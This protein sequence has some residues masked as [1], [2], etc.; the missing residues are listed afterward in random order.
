MIIPISIIQ[1]KSSLT[2]YIGAYHK[3]TFTLHSR[4]CSESHR[5][6]SLVSFEK[7]KKCSILY[8]SVHC[9][10]DSTNHNSWCIIAMCS[11]YFCEGW[12]EI[13]EET[14]SGRPMPAT[15]FKNIEGVKS[16]IKDN[17]YMTRE[18]LQEQTD[19]SHKS[20]QQSPFFILWHR[21]L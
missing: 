10:S 1:A 15:T 14:R 13:E 8:Q 7:D 11:K 6:T 17:P 3:K 4:G 2:V 18:E 21:F 20:I 16:V 5:R 19:L 12:E 9:A